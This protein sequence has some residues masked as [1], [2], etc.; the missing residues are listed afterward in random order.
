M[1][2]RLV[3]KEDGSKEWVKIGISEPKLK[4]VKNA[5]GEDLTVSGYIDKHG[6]I[7][8]HVDNKVYTTKNS[9]MEHLKANDCIIKD[10]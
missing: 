10:W 7:Y 3:I 5:Q 8:S 4:P 2:S 1:R 9:Y 6:G